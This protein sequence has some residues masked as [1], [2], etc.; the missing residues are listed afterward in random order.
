MKVNRCRSI[1]QRNK[2]LDNLKQGYTRDKK[3]NFMTLKGSLGEI[4]SNMCMHLV[5]EL[6]NTWSKKWIELKE[7]IDNSTT[8]NYYR[9]LEILAPLSS[10]V[11]RKIKTKI[12]ETWM[13]LTT[14]ST[15]VF[16]CKMKTI[17]TP[18]FWVPI[19]IK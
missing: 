11:D 17:I 14:P 15:T 8:I 12:Q 2:K 9:V 13:I 3:R 18:R 5:T 16:I 6:Q 10:A 1:Y 4:Q 7:E 19:R